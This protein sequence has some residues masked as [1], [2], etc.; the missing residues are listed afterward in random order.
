M[1]HVARSSPVHQVA[2]AVLCILFCT[3][4]PPCRAETTTNA[5]TAEISKQL[6]CFRLDLMGLEKQ[7]L[8]VSSKN[9]CL[10][11][12]YHQKD[13]HPYWVTPERPEEKASIVF[14]F[15]K[16]AESEGLDPANYEV[17]RIASLFSARDIKSL[18]ELEILLTFN[19]VKYIHDVRHGMLKTRYADPDLF[20]EAGDINFKPRTTMETMMAAPDLA[21]YLES[22]PPAHRHYTGLKKA[23]KAYRS[24][25]QNGG[26]PIIPKG[27]T[28]Q[29]GD[30]DERLPD[31]IRR[32][33]VT[34]D[35]N[36][37]M[38]RLP[39]TKEYIRLL[40]SAIVKFQVRHGLDPDGIIGTKT[41]AE[42]N[43]PVSDRIKQ[44][45]IN[46]TRWRWQEHDLGKRYVLINIANFDLKAYEAGMETFSF[47]VITGE[48]QTQTPIFSDH[49]KT[50]VIN[51]Y[52]TIPK[53]IARNEEL[54][55]L[56]KNPACLEN[57]YIRLFSDWSDNA[58][59]IDPTTVDWHAVTWARMGQ[60]RLR[61]DPGPWNALGRIKFIFPNKYKVYLHDTPS[62]SLFS[63]HKRNFSHGCIRVSD[64]LRLAVFAL[65]P[66]KGDKWTPETIK[67]AIQ[68]QERIGIGLREKLPIHITYQSAWI[69]KSGI[70]CFNYDVYGRD[71][72]LLRALFSEYGPKQK[73]K[74][75]IKTNR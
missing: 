17:D 33:G 65:S 29:P 21:E 71:E 38:A 24:I 46:M 40:K 36:P 10:T 2:C 31:I 19:L 27:P 61:Q 15:L 6:A 53:S 22:L 30:Y 4:A 32:L 18:A 41:L 73:S 54:Q 14:D 35:L 5:L 59:E 20:A 39:L 74:E 63:R 34:G 75:L 49:I 69:D 42:L 43:V 48:T 28:T 9:F 44:I 16:K 45:I 23:L 68:E 7:K 60:Y 56:R 26:W 70:V 51:P 3:L 12:I 8:A 11:A 55:K 47:P 72:K 13:A 1:S 66:Q 62:Q 52:W 64:P 25:K 57:R 58:T 50:V 37:T 67:N